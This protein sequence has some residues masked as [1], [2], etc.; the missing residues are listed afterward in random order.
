VLRQD[1]RQ[2]GLLSPFGIIVYKNVLKN[3][4]LFQI[5][6]LVLL[7]LAII[8]FAELIALIVYASKAACCRPATGGAVISQRGV[9]YQVPQ[10]PQSYQPNQPLQY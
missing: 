2:N 3:V 8:A 10:Q 7:I 1:K 4:L 5:S 6:L 9:Q